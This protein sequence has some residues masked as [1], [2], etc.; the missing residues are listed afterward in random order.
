MLKAVA[1][2]RTGKGDDVGALQQQIQG[3][4][5]EGQE[6]SEEIDRLKRER[7]SAASYEE[8]T[9]SIDDRINRQ[10]WGCEHA[11]QRRR[12]GCRRGRSSSGALTS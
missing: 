10:I 1:R 4:K 2:L 8:A 9:T 6:A 5:R 3:L 12:S 11:A 7:A